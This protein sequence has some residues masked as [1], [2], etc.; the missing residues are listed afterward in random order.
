MRLRLALVTAAL[1]V[2]GCS[3]GGSGSD[4]ETAPPAVSADDEPTVFVAEP[5][6]NDASMGLPA[7]TPDGTPSGADPAPVTPV[8]TL[9]IPPPANDSVP[10]PVSPAAETEPPVSER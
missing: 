7:R 1:I 4:K 10:Q 3:S 5:V 6:S 9:P 8:D 2:T